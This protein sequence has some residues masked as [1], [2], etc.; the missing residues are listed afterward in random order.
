M[1]IG[2]KRLVVGTV[3]ALVAVS[4]GAM[5]GVAF[6]TPTGGVIDACVDQYG[7]VRIIPS[8]ESCKRS[9]NHISWNQVGPQGPPGDP[10]SPGA[11]GA[12]GPQGL[13]GEDGALGATGP[14]GPAGL[15]GA[16]GTAGAT[17]PAGAD[18]AIGPTGPAGEPGAAGATGPAG[19]NGAPG[20]PGATGPVGPTG[21]AGAGLDGQDSQTA[22][23]T[24]ALI[25]SP[26]NTAFQV[27]PG[28][29]Q[30]VDVPADAVVIISTDGGIQ[31]TSESPTGF[32]A[33]TVAI[34]IDGVIAPEAGVRLVT[35]AN[36]GIIGI[37][38]FSMA[39]SRDLPAG[40]HTFQVAVAGA[41]GSN[42]IVSG[43]STSLLQG[44]LTVTVLKH[45]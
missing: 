43:N 39:L 6:L 37:G 41:G 25:V 34:A 23:G 45:E 20:A 9:E 33:A 42:F 5:A 14:A 28:L 35:A 38:N 1:R 30:T 32:S 44:Q 2:H 24:A 15:P 26:S 4:A 16:P 3:G 40:N 18:G 7:N 27:I 19:A 10:G 17:G 11:P 22:F 12:T 29:S 31:T 13:P 21:P 36:S 8:S